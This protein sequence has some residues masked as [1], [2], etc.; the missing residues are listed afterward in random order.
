MEL[1]SK[2]AAIYLTA[3]LEELSGRLKASRQR[4]ADLERNF[5]TASNSS[6]KNEKVSLSCNQSCVL[7]VYLVNLMR[8]SYLSFSL[9]LHVL[10][11]LIR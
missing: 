1:C 10:V 4:V 11:K 3:E 6:Q 8:E 2:F 9:S 5:T 7:M